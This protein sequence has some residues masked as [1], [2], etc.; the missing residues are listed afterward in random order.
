MARER[1]FGSAFHATYWQALWI[2]FTAPPLGMLA[3]AE[4]FLRIRGG[5]APKCAKL[6]HAN[7]K[8]CIFRCGYMPAHNK[9]E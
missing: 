3:A 1:S 2:Y 6:H 7:N 8:R 9:A 4:L 5:R